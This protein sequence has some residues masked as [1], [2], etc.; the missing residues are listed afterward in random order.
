MYQ[1]RGVDAL[2]IVGVALWAFGFCFEAIGDLQLDRFRRDL[3]N[4]GKI[5]DRGLWAWTRHPNYFGDVCVWAG[6]FVLALGSPWGIITVVS[7]ILMAR[8][9]LSYSGKALLE[10]RMRRSRGE[11]YEEY[12]ARTSGFFPLPSMQVRRQR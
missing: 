8:L 11:A 6:L 2:L 1:S 7:P 4:R 3:S 5:M 10:K 9:L 12:C